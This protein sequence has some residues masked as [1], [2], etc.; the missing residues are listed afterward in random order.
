MK[1]IRS[2]KKMHEF[3]RE[4]RLK[5]RS[6]GF[7]PTMGALHRGHL[8]L[9]RR[10]RRENDAVVVS[11][12]VNPIQFGRNEDF[13]A[14]PR[15]LRQD[16]RLCAGEGAD[17]VF[18]P[19]APSMYGDDFNACVDVNG[20]AE[21]LCGRFRP[22]HFKGVTTVVAKL[23]NIVSPDVAYF[24]QKDAQQSIIIKKMVSDLN[25]PVRIKVMPTVREKSGLALSSRN[26]YLSADEA[27][28][29]AVLYESLLLAKRL[30]RRG[31]D[32]PALIIGRMRQLIGSKKT[33][34]IQYVSI[35]DL[36]RLRPVEKIKGKVLVALAVYIGKIRLIDNLISAPR[37]K[38]HT[39]HA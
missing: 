35:V 31:E 22:G 7:I 10:A 28:D 21:V 24:G 3:S 26:A 37:G 14:Y 1:I 13:K 30:I 34:R 5:G 4:A 36:K 16:A 6:I 2:P 39:I 20:P 15:N 32:S 29:A 18:Y 27:R 11:I 8:S 9:I 38:G 12:F 33:A 25:I 19:S 23:F 17:A